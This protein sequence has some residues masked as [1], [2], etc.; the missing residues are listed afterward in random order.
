MAIASGRE[1]AF[2][3]PVRNHV[4]ESMPLLRDVNGGSPGAALASIVSSVVTRHFMIWAS[5][6]LTILHSE[7]LTQLRATMIEGIT[8]GCGR[9]GLV[10]P[11]F[12]SASTAAAAG[13][14]LALRPP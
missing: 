11:L 10:K 14:K 13:A 6:P 12:R 1:R 7:R 4:S 3:K 9:P 5:L 8:Q 2:G